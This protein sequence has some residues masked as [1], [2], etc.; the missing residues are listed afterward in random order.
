MSY[1]VVTPC[2]NCVKRKEGCID[3][4]V[5][6]GAVQGIIHAMPF[7]VGHKGAGTVTLECC[8][9]EEITEG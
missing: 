3:G 8:N 1:S 4:V 7:G 6:T 2:S 5:V 9:K